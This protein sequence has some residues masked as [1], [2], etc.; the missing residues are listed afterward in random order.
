M[1]TEYYF[2]YDEASYMYCVFDTESSKAH[3]SYA[4]PE[5]AEDRAEKLN[6]CNL[7][8]ATT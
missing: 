5:D 7:N 8:T 1:K 6:S 2:D 4:S 3:E